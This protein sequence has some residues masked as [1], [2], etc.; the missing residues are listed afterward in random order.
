VSTLTIDTL[1]AKDA[2]AP[3]VDLFRELFGESVTIT[4][5]LCVEHAAQFDWGWAAENLLTP[6]SRAEYERVCAP[7][8]AEYK[9]VCAE[10]FGRLYCAQGGQ[11]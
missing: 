9:R 10:T 6:N 4:P 1:T 5:E 8:W 2:C 3:Q 11:S 7:A